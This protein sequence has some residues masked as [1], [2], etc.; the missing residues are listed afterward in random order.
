MYNSP[1]AATVVASTKVKLFALDRITFRQIMADATSKKR[2]LHEQVSDLIRSNP[3]R[4]DP[5]RLP[6]SSPR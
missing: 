6:V 5:I 2:R 4:F 1:R 3:I